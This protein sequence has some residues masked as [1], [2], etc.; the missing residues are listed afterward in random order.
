[1]SM[2]GSANEDTYLEVRRTP[3]KYNGMD[4]SIAC[5]LRNLEGGWPDH[6]V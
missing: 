4:I 1:M 5:D 3:E 2:A 6:I